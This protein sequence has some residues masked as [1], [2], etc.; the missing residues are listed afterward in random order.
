[1][2]KEFEN[3]LIEQT[4]KT[5][6]IDLNQFTGELILSGRSIPENA[7]KVYEPV[8]NWAKEYI[9]KARPTTNVRLNLDYFN[10]SSSLW[11]VKI[12]KVLS[13][14]DNPDYVMIVHLYFH[15]EEFN[16]MEIEDLKDV[17]IPIAEI[18]PGAIPSIGV[19]IYGTDDKGIV[20]KDTVIFI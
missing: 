12:L 8:F 9:S 14:I 2:M 10:T 7:N 13:K 4:E 18:I 6:L 5:P 15:I 11:M 3:L 16:E 20:I 17:M 1:M 19:K